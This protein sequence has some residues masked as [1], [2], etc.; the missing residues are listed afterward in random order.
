MLHERVARRD[1]DLAPGTFSISVE[2]LDKWAAIFE[3]PS[4][5]EI[6]GY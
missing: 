2:E 6:R 3:P 1:L 5:E 4:I